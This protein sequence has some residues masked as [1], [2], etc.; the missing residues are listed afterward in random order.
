[1][2]KTGLVMGTPSF[3][4]PEQAA[5]VKDIDPRTDLYSMAVI[6]FQCVTGGLPHHA[7]NYNAL[8]VA[9]ISEPPISP[10]SLRPDLPEPFAAIVLRGLEKR[11]DDRYSSAA[12]MFYDL[13]PYVDAG[14]VAS[15]RAPVSPR[16]GAAPVPTLR[17]ARQ[18]SGAAAGDRISGEEPTGL[19]PD[20]VPTRAEPSAGAHARDAEGDRGQ[21]PWMGPG[22]ETAHAAPPRSPMRLILA[23]AVVLGLALGAVVMGVAL[24]YRDDEPRAARPAPEPA[25]TEPAGPVAPVPVAPAGQ[26]AETAPSPPEA[27]PRPGDAAVAPVAPVGKRPPTKTRPP[28]KVGDTPPHPF[29]EVDDQPPATPPRGLKELQ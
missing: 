18:A 19:S 14:A 17:A 24:K 11:R 25:A 6:L 23:A 7:D 26:G 13:R 27:G 10:L 16:G 2:T 21:P 4:S 12:E 15:L 9:I 8:M 20:S 28:V 3:M 29:V 1:M 5:G 22:P